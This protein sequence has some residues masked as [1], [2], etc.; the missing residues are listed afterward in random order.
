MIWI[1]SL[2]LLATIAQEES[3]LSTLEIPAQLEKFVQLYARAGIIAPREA[4]LLYN[5]HLAHINHNKKV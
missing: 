4:K 1:R 3:Q 5:A 2:A